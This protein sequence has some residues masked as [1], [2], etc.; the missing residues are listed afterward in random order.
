MTSG[1]A[2]GCAPPARKMNLL[3]PSPLSER[4]G[5]IPSILFMNMMYY[6]YPI[7]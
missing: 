7:T 3:P 5:T 6:P 4:E 1:A 2:P